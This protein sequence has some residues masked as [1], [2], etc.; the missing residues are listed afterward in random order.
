M[1][2]YSNSTVLGR[3]TIGQGTVI[4]GNLWVTEG[5]RPGEKLMQKN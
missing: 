1:I 5:T 3:I 2:I 4:G